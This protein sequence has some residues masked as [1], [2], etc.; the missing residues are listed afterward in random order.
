MVAFSTLANRAAAEPDAAF[1]R[2][3]PAEVMGDQACAKCHDHEIQQ[4]KG[5][6]HY[7]TFDTLHRR[8]EAK[9]I[10]KRLGLRSVKRNDTCVQCHY[11][12]QLVDE[13]VRIVAGVSCESCHGAAKAWITLHSD[14]GSPNATKESETPEHRQQRVEQSL[15]AG[16]NNPVNLY[17]LARQCLACHT[18]PDEKLVNIGG[19]K[20]GS[21]EF[22]L[23]SWS[24]GMVRHNFLASGGQLNQPSSPERLRVMYVVGVMADLEASLRAT[25]LATEKQTFGITAA[26]RAA[27]LKKRLYEIGQL[28]DNQHLHQALDIVMAV[29]LKLNNSAA[30]SGAADEVGWAANALAQ[31]ESGES[32]APIDSL[33]PS[34]QQYKVR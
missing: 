23:V 15:A 18:A 10:A 7:E 19:H 33:L 13:R 11:T 8:P 28:V 14:Y 3:D 29:Q 2:Y 20:A 17:L 6:P 21:T 16:M 4:W 1:V 30:L 34:P 12:R 5:T 24:Q 32:L 31:S 25:A 22:E 26:Q 9:E 27:R